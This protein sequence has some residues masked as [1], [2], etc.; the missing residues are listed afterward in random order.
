MPCGTVSKFMKDTISVGLLHLGMNVVARISEFGNLFGK[1]LD[2]I[3]GVAKYNGLVYFKL[4]KESIKAVHLLSLFD[5]GVKLSDTTKG[6]L[7]HKVDAVRVRYKFLAET[8]NSNWESG[9]K[10]AD[11]MVGVAKSYDLLEDRLEFRREQLV[12]FVHDNCS[13]FTEIGNFFGSQVEN[14]TW[15]G[16]DDVNGIVKTHDIVL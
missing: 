4:R 6:E 13:A 15:R 10:E 2:T 12:C 11:L 9:T 14:A 5:V 7:V 1:Q 8:F 16:N 3:D